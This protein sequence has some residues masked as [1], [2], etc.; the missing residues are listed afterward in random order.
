[1]G[2]I[3]SMAAPLLDT[4]LK[5][6]VYLFCYLLF[7]GVVL[8][9]GITLCVYIDHRRR[10]RL[11]RAVLDVE[12]T[13]P[14]EEDEKELLEGEDEKVPLL[15]PQSYQGQNRQFISDLQSCTYVNEKLSLLSS[16]YGATSPLRVLD[17]RSNL[18]FTINRPR[19][20]ATDTTAHVPKY[21][22]KYG[23]RCNEM[24][25]NS[26]LGR[27]TPGQG[28]ITSPSRAPRDEEFDVVIEHP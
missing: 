1:M 9:I 2:N 28:G 22:T 11:S 12:R 6:A 5:I 19:R 21:F 4:D 23:M 24:K 18:E 15:P 8:A 7:I 25:W 27:L 10:T 3:F 17:K 16:R 26:K 13:S 14:E 20:S